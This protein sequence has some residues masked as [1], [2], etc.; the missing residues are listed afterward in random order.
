MRKMYSLLVTSMLIIFSMQVQAKDN[1]EAKE[2]K[3]VHKQTSHILIIG[4]DEN[5]KSNYYYNG[6][7]AEETGIVADSI[8]LEFN[9]IIS[10]NIA[11][12]NKDKDCKFVSASPE[13]VND[14]L[15]QS[16]K[17]SGESEDCYSDITSVSS[18]EWQ[19]TL[20]KVNADYMLILNQHYLKWQETPLRTLFHIVSYTVFDKDKKE[21]CR[22]NQYF[23]S[24][25]LEKPEILR[26]ISLKSTSKIASNVTKSLKA[27]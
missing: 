6:M 15:L 24:M 11:T 19:K 14:Q 16:I 23:T 25:H 12:S 10:E 27:N 3:D 9:R 20:D 21:V 7:I 17:V 8:D 18:D 4:L 5:V 2:S 26:K 1:K 22:G 13:L